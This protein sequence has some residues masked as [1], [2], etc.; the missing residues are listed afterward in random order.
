MART[1]QPGDDYLPA[2]RFRVLTPLFDGVVKT[3]MREA[4]FKTMLLDQ[5]RLE[6]GQRLLDLGCG[7]GTLALLAAEREPGIEVVGLDADPE[8]LVRARRKAADAGIAVRFDEGLSTDLPYENASFDR[9][10]STL[11]FHHLKPADK[12]GTAEEIARV[13]R[14]GGELHVTDF[15][16]PGGVL[17]QLAFQTVRVFDGREP[18]RENV[19]GKLP[20][21][22]EQ[23]G[24]SEAIA[25]TSLRTL[26]GR[27][28]LYSATKR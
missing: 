26:L 22:F 13:L 19:E 2:L 15:G 1:T 18:T 23:G 27:L 24:L 10:L 20:E 3:T 8:I 4:R 5:A 25:Q 17:M 12:R 7:T 6:P 11:F 9:V 14:P 16:P 28:Y 21:I